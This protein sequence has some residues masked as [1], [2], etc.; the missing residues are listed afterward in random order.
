[1]VDADSAAPDETVD[2]SEGDLI[3]REDLL[4][5][6]SQPSDGTAPSEPCA[7]CFINH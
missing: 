6:V 1:M 2:R 3:D 4:G 5:I 7:S